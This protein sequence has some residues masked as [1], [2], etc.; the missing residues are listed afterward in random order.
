MKFMADEMLGKLAKWLRIFGYDTLYLRHVRDSE[1]LR[2]SVAEKRILL[3]RDTNL[4]KRK[5][6]KNFLFI[7]Y[8][9]LFAQ[10]RQVV[11]ELG[12]PYPDNPFSRCLICNDPL[13][14]YS[15]EEACRIVPQYVGRTQEVFGQCPGCRRIYWKGTHYERMEKMSEAVFTSSPPPF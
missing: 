12:I 7:S 13:V 6:V 3:T 2:L 4:I 8:D 14:P 10:L 1:L 11:G 5:G 15:R 9:H